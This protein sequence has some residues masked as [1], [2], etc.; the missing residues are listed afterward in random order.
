MW[1]WFIKNDFSL[2]F[3]FLIDPLMSFN[4]SKLLCAEPTRAFPGGRI[5]QIKIY[6]EGLL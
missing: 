4:R 6:M 3:G 5:V 2:E 1:S